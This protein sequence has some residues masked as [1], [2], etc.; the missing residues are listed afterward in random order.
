MVQMLI[1]GKA[2]DGKGHHEPRSEE[3]SHGTERFLLG[4]TANKDH[5]HSLLSPTPH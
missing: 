4:P 3:K 5:T 2:R 1:P